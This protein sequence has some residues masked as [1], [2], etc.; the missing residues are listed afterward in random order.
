MRIYGHGPITGLAHVGPGGASGLR[1]AWR[2]V[3]ASLWRVVLVTSLLVLSG[4]GIS[5]LAA[6]EPDA[7]A[8]A[9]PPVI[10]TVLIIRKNVFSEQEV[11]QSGIFRTM[12]G[13]HVVTKER[14][15]R[16]YLQ[17]A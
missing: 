5:P 3:R 6:Q 8:E 15:V 10:D 4:T 7:V 16:D 2:L 17:F 12:N 11:A 13:I 14:V 1:A 9:S